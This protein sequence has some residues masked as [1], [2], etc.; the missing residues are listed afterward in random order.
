MVLLA[1]TQPL[2]VFVRLNG[3]RDRIIRG[4]TQNQTI[5]LAPSLPVT[6]RVQDKD[7]VAWDGELHLQSLDDPLSALAPTVYSAAM[8][9]SPPPYRLRAIGGGG[10]HL[11]RQH[12]LQLL[13]V[14]GLQPG[15]G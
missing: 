10:Q 1:T 2:D 12:P 15:R 3:C 13:P 14:A 7:G 11:L 9:G 4:I 6:L 8:G 5:E